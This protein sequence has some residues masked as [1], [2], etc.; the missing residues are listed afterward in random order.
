MPIDIENLKKSSS[1]L[2]SIIFVAAL[3]VGFVKFFIWV[4]VKDK[5]E[6][7]ERSAAVCPALL[8]IGRSSRDTLIVMRA[9]PLC[10]DY[11]LQNFK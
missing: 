3:A 7:A 8:S 10:N 4:T 5:T 9:E 6:R 2:I 1:T 11:V